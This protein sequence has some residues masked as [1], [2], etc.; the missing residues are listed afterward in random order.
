MSYE[1]LN[2]GTQRFDGQGFLN[3]TA[4]GYAFKIYHVLAVGSTNNAQISLNLI[5]STGS[6]LT[7]ATNN[8]NAYLTLPLST[9][10]TNVMGVW[11]SH[12][13]T[14]VNGPVLL[15]TCVGFSYAVVQYNAVKK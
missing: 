9:S 10:G 8:T 6:A 12:Y 2:V 14:L 3:P 7:T 5:S 15:H 11:D 13:G 4:T 1:Y